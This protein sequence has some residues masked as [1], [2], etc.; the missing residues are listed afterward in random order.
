MGLGDV[1]RWNLHK[2]IAGDDGYWPSVAS[3]HAGQIRR[4]HD[5]HGLFLSMFG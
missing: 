5:R 4:F 3:S 2:R 1:Q